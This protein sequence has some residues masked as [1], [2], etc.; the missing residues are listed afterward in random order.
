MKKI[1]LILV[2]ASFGTQSFAYC[3]IPQWCPDAPLHQTL[4]PGEQ[5]D[6]IEF[7]SVI[8]KTLIINW[9]LDGTRFASIGTPPGITVSGDASTPLGDRE[10][11]WPVSIKGTPTA[12]G[13]HHYT[14]SNTCGVELLH[15]S[16]T[17]GPPAPATPGTIAFSNN[18]VCTGAEFTASIAAVSNATTYNWTVPGSMTHDGSD[19][20]TI[21]ITDAGTTSGSLAISVTA[22]NTCGTSAPSTANITIGTVPSTPGTIT[23]SPTSACTGGTF[24]AS[25]PAVSGLT[26]TWTLPT[27]ATGM[28]SNNSTTN[29]LSVTNAGSVTGSHQF[30]VIAHNDC[31]AS[32]TPSTQNITI[33]AAPAAPGTITFSPTSVG[34]GGAFTASVAA[35]A[36]AASYAWTVPAGMTSNNSTTNTLSVTNAGTTTGARTFSV[37]ASNTCGTSDPTSGDITVTVPIPVCAATTNP[38]PSDNGCSPTRNGATFTT[39]GAQFFKTNTVWTISGNGISQEWSDVVLTSNCGKTGFAGGSGY[40]NY[41]NDCRGNRTTGT[42]ETRPTSTNQGG[43]TSAY[44]GDLFSWCA[45]MTHAAVLCPSPWR[46]PT[47]QDFINL[48]VAL[49]GDGINRSGADAVRDKLIDVSGTSGAGQ[50]WGGAYVGYCNSTGTLSGQGSTAVYWSSSESTTTSARYLAFDTDGIV[51]PQVNNNKDNGFALRCVR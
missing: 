18:P 3:P 28:T 17:L 11:A 38:T 51:N 30:A 7:P 19:G 21:N 26:Y 46:V 32:A 23:F 10:Y 13:T 34:T 14:V 41:N 25:V 50:F 29:T 43:N 45:V 42:N 44:F 31:G 37:T 22:S 15:G 2:I 27:T 1:T 40:P 6:P 5:I 47:C 9:W 12:I 36:G 20:T 48:D 33:N 35:V 4:C 39:I 8:G 16:I 49:G 24:T